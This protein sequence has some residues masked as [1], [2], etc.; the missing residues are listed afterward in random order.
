MN[1]DET[2]MFSS[3]GRKCNSAE[4]VIYT[5]LF[6]YLSAVTTEEIVLQ[7]NMIQRLN[8]FGDRVAYAL[9]IT[10]IQEVGKKRRQ[11]KGVFKKMAQK[12]QLLF[13]NINLDSEY[14][15]TI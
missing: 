8:C 12:T 7:G 5:G 6:I 2:M 1:C 15:N 10:E 9:N 4:V 14:S 11:T 3:S 13:K